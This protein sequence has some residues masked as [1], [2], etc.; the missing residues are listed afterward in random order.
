MNDSLPQ[1]PIGT[2]LR[3]LGHESLEKFAAIKLRE[4]LLRQME[5]SKHRLGIY[6]V[7]YG[8][9][10]LSVFREQYQVF[11]LPEFEKEE[12]L[13]SWEEETEHLQLLEAHLAALK[14]AFL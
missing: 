11:H 9:S 14:T 1:S 12:D 4:E 7:K 8:G 13:E 3:F 10:T 6:A 2:A 5:H